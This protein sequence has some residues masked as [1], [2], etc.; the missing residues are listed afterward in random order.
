MKQN[1]LSKLIASPTSRYR[2][3]LS[4]IRFNGKGIASVCFLELRENLNDSDVCDILS[5]SER[6]I[7]L[8]FKS[9]SAKTSYFLGR[10]ASGLALQYQENRMSDIIIRNGVFGQPIISDSA[11]DISITHTKKISACIVYDKFYIFGI[12][13]EPKNEDFK[14]IVQFFDS[15]EIELINQYGNSSFIIAWTLKE[16]LSKAIRCGISIPLSILDI[17]K[18]TPYN[19]LFICEFSNFPQYK[20]VSLEWNEYR[21][22]L[23]Y[24]SLQDLEHEIL[25]ALS[26]S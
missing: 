17:K 21:I 16:A 24:P 22:S 25:Y 3:K 26:T 6:E 9:L 7:F 20:G 13:A 19:D 12:D 23:V 4:K 8:N 14:E 15:N 2:T 10:C 5:T 11:Y 18:L 1:V